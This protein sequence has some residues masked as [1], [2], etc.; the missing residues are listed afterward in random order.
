MDNSSIIFVDSNT[1]LSIMIR[2]TRQKIN[3]DIKELNNTIN[4]SNNTINQS[5]FTNINITL[6]PATAKCNFFKC[7]WYSR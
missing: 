1:Q 5:Y 7:A 3:E 2:K 6:H 4:Q